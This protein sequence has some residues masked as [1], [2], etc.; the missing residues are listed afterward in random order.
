MA[1]RAPAADAACA[2]AHAIERLLATPTTRPVLL[3]SSVM[4]WSCEDSMI[5]AG[6]L[7][8]EN[9]RLHVLWSIAQR[10]RLRPDRNPAA[11]PPRPLW[12]RPP[13]PAGRGPAKRGPPCERLPLP[14]AP[15]W[16]LL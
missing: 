11:G 7:S 12:F 9:R 1:S 6:R 13:G 3:A 2:I 16:P 4:A 10:D 14:P 5:A 8:D 15:E